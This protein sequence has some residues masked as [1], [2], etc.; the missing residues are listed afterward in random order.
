MTTKD[1]L[2]DTLADVFAGKEEKR[3]YLKEYR[4]L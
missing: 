2:R 3:T 1:R 4:T